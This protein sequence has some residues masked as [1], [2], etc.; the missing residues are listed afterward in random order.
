MFVRRKDEEQREA[1]R[2]RAELGWSVSRIA[3]ELGVAK[4][5][6]SVWVRGISPPGRPPRPPGAVPALRLPVW[7]SGKVRRCSRCGLY[8]PQESFN[9]S[10]EGFQWYC[11]LCFAA[12]FRARG[13]VHRA[14][15]RAAKQ[16][17][18]Q[19]LHSHILEYLRAHPCIE[20]GEGDPVVLDFDHVGDKNAS[21]SA[22]VTEVAPI[23][24]IDA[25]IKQCEVVCANC[26]RRRTAARGVWRRADPT[27]PVRRPYV[28]RAV[29]RNFAHLEAVLARSGCIDCGTR[30]TLVLEFD[31]VGPKRA[32]VSKLAW[33]GC[34]LATIDAEIAQCEVRC[35]NCHRRVTGL[36]GAYFR[37]RVLSSVAPP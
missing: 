6:V 7:R 28:T 8:L 33:N 3:R 36:R 27:E 11:R 20:C 21:I 17:R 12:Y 32:S 24:A 9:R 22:F 23:A 31:H 29:A 13:D 19:V 25:E 5:S 35:A 2:L 30:D 26:H 15:S 1:R 4:S 10:G 34:S 14:Q 37:S 18:Q 16:A